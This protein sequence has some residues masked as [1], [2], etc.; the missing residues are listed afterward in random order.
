MPD[1]PTP[2]AIVMPYV[3]DDPDR[4]YEV[5]GALRNHGLDPEA[6]EI[7]IAQAD[8]EIATLRG[9]LGTM[10]GEHRDAM[11]ER[12]SLK[13]IVETFGTQRDAHAGSTRLLEQML[14]NV[15]PDPG[16]VNETVAHARD[17]DPLPTDDPD[18]PDGPDDG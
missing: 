10:E 2:L 17:L 7:L 1:R 8:A 9:Q 3:D 5:L 11:R 6:L 18:E 15:T 13:T 16:A 14:A 12:E 4:A